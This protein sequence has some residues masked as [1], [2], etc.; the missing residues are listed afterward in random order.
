MPGLSAHEE[1]RIKQMGE[2]A[3]ERVRTKIKEMKPDYDRY[4]ADQGGADFSPKV[5][6]LVDA[7][8]RYDGS[9]GPHGAI[10]HLSKAHTIALDLVAPRATIE[11]YEKL[12]EREEA[13]LDAIKA[14]EKGDT[15]QAD[16][17]HKLFDETGRPLQ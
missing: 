5:Q 8:L 2:D 15:S 16:E 1:A 10:W 14:A 17:L 6:A 7:V 9:M 3:L 4:I 13:I 12:K 11:E